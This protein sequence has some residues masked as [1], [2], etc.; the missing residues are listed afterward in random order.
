METICRDFYTQL[1]ASCIAVPMPSLQQTDEHILTVLISEIRHAVHQMK[2]GKSP[3][4]DGLTAEVLK[5]GGQELWKA[6][7]QR[8][9][10]YLEIQKILSSWKESNTILLHKKGNREN[11]K[12]YC[13]IC[14]LLHI[15]KLFTKIITNQLSRNLD[16]QQPREQ[17]SFQRN[18]S[19][20]DHL[21]T[22]NQLLEHSRECKFPL[23]IA[24]VN[25]EKAFDSVET[26]TVLEA[27][28][29]QGIIVKYITLLKEANSVCSTDIS[30]FDTP[31][32]IPI[33]K[34]VKQGYNFT[35]IIHSLS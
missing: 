32:R 3:G 19:T 25:Y 34:S 13:P 35:K 24:F 16:E 10:R 17:A 1:F 4:K 9:S 11:L 6:L 8:F 2:E 31:L 15:Y 14:L 7:A 22:L 21:F 28:S 12:N 33:E 20:I 27:L 23:C 29:E 30:L 26:N 18:Y 5:V